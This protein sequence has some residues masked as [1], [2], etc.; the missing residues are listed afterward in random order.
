MNQLA[1]EET[2]ETL[3]TKLDPIERGPLT[4]VARYVVLKQIKERLEKRM[5]N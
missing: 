5:R 1:L 3:L 2:D 4:Y